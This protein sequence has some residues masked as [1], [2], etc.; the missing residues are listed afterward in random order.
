MLSDR[1][2]KVDFCGDNTHQTVAYDK[3]A[4]FIDNYS[5]FSITKKRDLLD[6]IE[7]AKKLLRKE[8]YHE[9]ERSISRPDSKKG[10]IAGV[11]SKQDGPKVP[12]KGVM[13]PVMKVNSKPSTKVIVP[14]TDE[15]VLEGTP[16]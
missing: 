4:D 5:K 2:Y 16:S 13:T 7:I 3:V 14:E 8:D 11:T 1:K 15:E 12:S 10:G 9:L 6:S